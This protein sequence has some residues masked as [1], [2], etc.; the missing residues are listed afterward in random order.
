MKKIVNL[1]L[2][3][4]LL[5]FTGGCYFFNV[6][7]GELVEIRFYNLNNEEIKGELKPFGEVHHSQEEEKKQENT[8]LPLNSP[9]PLYMY[10]YAEVETD[11]E[12]MVEFKIHYT[13]D[14]KFSSMI[15][16]EQT[17]LTED[18]ETIEVTKEHIFLKKKFSVKDMPKEGY[19][20][21]QFIMKKEENEKEKFAQGSTRIRDTSRGRFEGFFFR[22]VD[23]NE[24]IENE[25]IV[26]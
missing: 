7:Y 9:A 1:I 8:Y 22:L 26:L 24:I 17:F 10:Y 3:I 6:E 19:V 18:F 14:Y 11:E 2:L 25:N 13:Y 5:F 20:I 15:I 23:K 21:H 4:V 16:G 12:I